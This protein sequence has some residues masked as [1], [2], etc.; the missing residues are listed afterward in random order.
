[1]RP[2]HNAGDIRVYQIT[3]AGKL[4]RQWCDWF[5]DMA[6]SVG[7][8]PDGT[9]VTTLSGVAADQATLRGILNKIWDLN[10]TLISVIRISEIAG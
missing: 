5:G 1:M 8:A 2:N 6:V 4:D 9:L 10:L 7:Q 3:V